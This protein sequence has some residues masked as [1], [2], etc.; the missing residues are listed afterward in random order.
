L[1]P[2]QERKRAEVQTFGSPSSDRIR[3]APLAVRLLLAGWVALAAATASN[4]AFAYCRT[5]IFPEFDYDDVGC[6][7]G[8]PIAWMSSCVTYSMQFRASKHVDLASATTVLEQ[9]FAV[10]QEVSC[11]DTGAPPAIAVD[12]R[13]GNV[14][15]NLHEYNQTDANANIIVFRDDVWP[16]EAAGNVLALTTV[17]Y[18]NK[19]GAIFDVDMEVNSTQP[20]SVGDPVPS[21]S[22]DLQSIVTHEAGHF[23]GMAHSLDNKATMWPQYSSGTMSFRMLALDDAEGIC[24]VYPAQTAGKCDYAPRQGFATEC[25]IFPSGGS[26]HCAIAGPG[27]AVQGGG[28]YRWLGLASAFAAAMLGWRRRRRSHAVGR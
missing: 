14:A 17:T 4:P 6:P 10:W 21:T 18:S 11:S 3:S 20:I 24:A 9:A 27:P 15:C 16:Y 13:Y 22:Y 26:G 25:G 7:T 12:H 5:T 1:V 2:K 8:K 23:L 19:S 28:A